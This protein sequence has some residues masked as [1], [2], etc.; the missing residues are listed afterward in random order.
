M[1]FLPLFMDYSIF[2]YVESM[3]VFFVVL[4]VYFLVN[5]RILLSSIV[6]GL[7]ILTKYN[8]IFILPVLLYFVYRIN[9]NDKKLL[10]RNLLITAFVPLLISLPWFIRNWLILGNPIWPFLNFIFKGFEA[11]SYSNFNGFDYIFNINAIIFTYLGFFG[12]PDGNPQNLLFFNIP[13]INLLLIIWL[14]GTLIFILPLA[15]GFFIKRIKIKYLIYAWIISYL[16]LFLLYVANVS[17]SVSR[18]LLPA[19]PALAVLWAYG[20]DYLLKKFN[21]KNFIQII[22]ILIIFG[23][24]FTETIKIS[25][26]AQQW[27]SYK[28]DFEWVREN[29]K[30]SDIIIAGGQCLSYNFDRQTLTPKIENLNKADYIWLNQ[31]FMLD[32]R[33]IANEDFLLKIKENNYNK[34]YENKQTGTIIYAKQ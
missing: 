3:L 22:L 1:A 18:M 24:I 21:F 7:S 10:L 25:L 23:L 32:K 31:R 6:A 2:S 14:I 30:K 9:K 11:A 34:I 13:Y 5:G 20:F 19:V 15:I 26:A 12:V 27:N 4:S 17:W 28:K 29:T 33:A 8:G 16:I